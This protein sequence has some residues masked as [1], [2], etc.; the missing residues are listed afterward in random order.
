MDRLN[1]LQ[2]ILEKLAAV[3][4]ILLDVLEEEHTHMVQLDIPAL[5]EAAH[6]KEVLLAEIWDLEQLRQKT[7]EEI[8][9]SRGLDP[10]KTTLKELSE[11]ISKSTSAE[12]VN[13]LASVREVLQLLVEQAKERNQRNMTFAN[14]SLAR[15]EELKRNV[16]GLSSPSSKE[17]YSNQGTRQPNAEQGGRLLS[18]EA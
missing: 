7:V 4:R 6:A 13:K 16:L 8:A 17:N 2:F 14:D 12:T 18:T 9:V 5:G 1:E 10:N 11:N 3:H 15:I